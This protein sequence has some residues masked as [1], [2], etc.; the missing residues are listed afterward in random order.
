MDP[1]G[2]KVPGDN[3]SSYRQ[4]LGY[5]SYTIAD[6]REA[7]AELDLAI[8][9]WT[10]PNY[11]VEVIVQAVSYIGSDVS[12]AS[13]TM[14]WRTANASGK[15]DIVTG[16]DGS[17]SAFIN[18]TDLPE[19]NRSSVGDAININVVW[20]GPTRERLE[21]SGSQFPDSVHLP[22]HPFAIAATIHN[23]D[24]GGAEVGVPIR[25][26]VI[27]N[28]SGLSE[29][30]DTN[31]TCD[32]ESGAPNPLACQLV[33]PCMGHYFLEGCTNDGKEEA[34]TQ[35]SYG[36]NESEWAADP[37]HQH[38]AFSL[39]PEKGSYTV[40][41]D[42]VLHF[43]NI[44]PNAS[45]LL[46]WGNDPELQN[47]TKY[48]ISSG[49]SNVSISVGSKFYQAPATSAY[50]WDP[51]VKVTATSSIQPGPSNVSISVGSECQGDCNLLAMLQVPRTSLSKS[52]EIDSVPVSKLFDPE[53]P[54][55][56][57][58]SLDLNIAEDRSLDVVVELNGLNS[59][60][61]NDTPVVASPVNKAILDM[62]PYPLQ[63][64]I[65]QDLSLNLATYFGYVDVDGQRVAPQALDEMFSAVMRR[66]T[67][68][69]WVPPSTQIQV[70]NY[71]SD[72][73]FPVDMNDTAF[74]QQYS[75]YITQEASGR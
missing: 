55:Q 50:P 14:T 29:E 18:M 26:S 57:S 67:I 37:W 41:D 40:G 4:S 38:V 28:T 20:I 8:P 25:V 64:D 6:P 58:Y 11:K 17:G 22:G 44:W 60:T 72:R 31:Q 63:S 54:H 43:Q 23:S 53:A 5:E 2:A 42:V 65:A 73:A 47:M 52:A 51:S 21:Q 74:F 32:I 30:C 69:P 15:E 66:Y 48:E 1:S 36:R 9:S 19:I 33:L 24:S 12:G 70:H 27:L 49:S 71:Y 56:Q 13:M 62:L 46:I 34:C 59:S 3:A 35:I 39:E 45:L 10:K 7:T 75:T 61:D 68:D 16:A